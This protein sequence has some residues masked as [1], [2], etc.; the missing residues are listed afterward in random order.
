MSEALMIQ[1]VGPKDTK[2]VD[3]RVFR[4]LK[5]TKCPED[6]FNRLTAHPDVFLPAD[7]PVPD[8]VLAQR[9]QLGAA[10][11]AEGQ[12]RVEGYRQVYYETKAW[13]GGKIDEETG[14]PDDAEQK[15]LDALAG[16]QSEIDF[17][18]RHIAAGHAFNAKVAAEAEAAEKA[19]AKGKAG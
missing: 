16:A 8:E 10:M 7:E 17:A 9:Q 19:S 2:K 1:Y 13:K 11:I 3:G 4:R 15:K 6:L 12:A 5:P 14:K 18:E